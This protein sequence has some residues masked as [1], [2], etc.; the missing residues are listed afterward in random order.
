M[1][2]KPWITTSLLFLQN[3]PI[4][5][6]IHT[7]KNNNPHIFHPNSQ[8]MKTASKNWA[9]KK[10]RSS[11]CY[12]R[13][14]KF[15]PNYHLMKTAFDKLSIANIKNFETEMKEREEILKTKIDTNIGDLKAAASSS[16]NQT[17]STLNS[18][19]YHSSSKQPS[20]DINKWPLLKSPDFH[21]HASQFTKHL[22]PMNLEDGTLLQLKKWW[23]TIRSAFW[24]SLSTNKSWLPFSSHQTLILNTSQ[25][26]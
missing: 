8:P 12:S 5:G 2:W 21:S 15:C 13:S 14:Q 9:S 10:Q 19:N 3:L 24:K 11:P 26:K 23:D 1:I 20:S 17:F 6:P 4:Q 18:H 22:P 25:Q 7:S 16:I